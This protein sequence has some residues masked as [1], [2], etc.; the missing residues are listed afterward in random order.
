MN[1]KLNTQPEMSDFIKVWSDPN[2]FKVIGTLANADQTF[3]KIVAVTKLS[4]NDVSHHLEKL[5]EVGLV[6]KNAQ[7]SYELRFESLFQVSKNLFAG[8]IE[9][10]ALSKNDEFDEAARVL[11]RYQN[12]DGSLRDIPSIKK[13]AHLEAVLN[14]VIRAFVGDRIYTEK[15]VNKILGG[16]HADFVSLRRYLVD[17]QLLR[18]TKNG[19]E[20]WRV[21][22]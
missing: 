10:G 19:A 6:N 15:E 9:H 22:S 16:F 12:P 8:E 21:V 11:K 1:R 20:Y 13:K 17:Y 18:R 14:Y 4:A 5:I 3:G 7:G 2:R